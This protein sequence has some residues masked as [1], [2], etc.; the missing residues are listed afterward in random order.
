[1]G[2]HLTY[3]C[4]LTIHGNLILIFLYL[5][6]ASRY[7]SVFPWHPW[8]LAMTLGHLVHCVKHIFN[9]T[10]YVTNNEQKFWAI[11]DLLWNVTQLLFQ[12]CMYRHG[13][14]EGDEQCTQRTHTHRLS[15]HKSADDALPEMCAT[16]GMTLTFTPTSS[17]DHKGTRLPL[18]RRLSCMNSSSALFRV[19]WSMSLRASLRRA[20]GR[21]SL[22]L[23]SSASSTPPMKSSVRPGW[24]RSAYIHDHT[25]TSTMWLCT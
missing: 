16:R 2:F 19:Y 25:K 13:G 24:A 22:S 6:K 9:C 23:I 7:L 12:S 21:L 11:F 15:W 10:G 5:T 8:V 14:G 18:A 3:L 1:M 17:I 4:S 20:S